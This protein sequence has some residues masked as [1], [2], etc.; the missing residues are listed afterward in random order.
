M[1]FTEPIAIVALFI[2]GG[3]LGVVLAS[4]GEERSGIDAVISAALRA[5]AIGLV[6]CG[7]GFLAAAPPL[8]LPEVARFGVAAATGALWMWRH[9]PEIARWIVAEHSA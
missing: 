5:F 2:T 9:W 4:D 8:A 6:S 7:V 1:P 3:F